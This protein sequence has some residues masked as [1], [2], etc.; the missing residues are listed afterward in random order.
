M[1]HPEPI[2][3]TP[4]PAG[5]AIAAHHDSH[6]ALRRGM[7][8][9]LPGQPLAR[10]LSPLPRHPQGVHFQMDLSHLGRDYLS[11]SLHR[12][13]LA[14]DPYDQF[15]HW[16]Q[17]ACEAQ[18]LEPNAMTLAT[19]GT[20]ARPT[21]R[22]VLLKNFDHRGFVFFTNL[23]SNKAKQIAQNPEVSLLFPWLS[24]ERQVIISGRAAKVSPEETLDYFLTRPLRSQLAAWASPQSSLISSRK[25]L[26][27]K[28]A[29][30]EEKF[31]HGKVPL[32]PFWGGYRVEPHSIEFWQGGAGRLHDRF[33][34]THQPGGNWTI[35]RLAP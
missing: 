19:A 22:T 28:F 17:Q 4:H 25:V 5:H 2:K 3:A 21:Q 23:E 27:M 35:D 16:F 9:P 12:D 10:E 15:H 33:L 18:L 32:P 26:E 34:Y 13:D 11:Q 31:R 8:V 20:D 30:I 6:Q 1:N 7:P 29:E 24:L 14:D